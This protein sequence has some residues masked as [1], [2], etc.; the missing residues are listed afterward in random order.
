[1]ELSIHSLVLFF[2]V[3]LLLGSLLA[4]LLF[5]YQLKVNNRQDK[6]LSLIIAIAFL[7]YA[8]ST[9]SYN[10]KDPDYQTILTGLSIFFILWAF[11]LG[12]ARQE[13]L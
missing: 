10:T 6:N 13:S 3:F 4:W 12:V 5:Y 11:K 7:A 9:W 1:M 8:F 2:S